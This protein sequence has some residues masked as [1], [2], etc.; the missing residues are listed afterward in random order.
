MGAKCRMCLHD[1]GHILISI[2][3]VETWAKDGEWVSSASV[4]EDIKESID[5]LRE[6]GCITKASHRELVNTVQEIEDALERKDIKLLSAA[7]WRLNYTT[8]MKADEIA[9]FCQK[10]D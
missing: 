9:R 2:P 8:S 7:L 4:V 10:G 5:G 3:S 1:Y 6:T